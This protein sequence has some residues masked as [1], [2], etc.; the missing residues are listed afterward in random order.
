MELT[1]F[2]SKS[3]LRFW[4]S[5]SVNVFLTDGR[6]FLVASLWAG[7]IQHGPSSVDENCILCISPSFKVSFVACGPMLSELSDSIFDS[8]MFV[9]AP[10]KPLFKLLVVS[11]SGRR[12]SCPQEWSKRKTYSNW[13]HKFFTTSMQSSIW[14]TMWSYFQYP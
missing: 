4:T 5:R 9:C 1:P 2:P 11:P 7:D 13:G 6:S 12:R 8:L 14:R 10:P 3:F